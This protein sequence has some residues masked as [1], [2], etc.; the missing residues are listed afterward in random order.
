MRRADHGTGSSWSEYLYT[1]D[2]A[3]KTCT[4][5]RIPRSESFDCSKLGAQCFGNCARFYG[6]HVTGSGGG[7]SGGAGNTSSNGQNRK[8][9]NGSSGPQKSN[10]TS[11]YQTDVWSPI[12]NY[13]TVTWH[14]VSSSRA[15]FNSFSALSFLLGGQIGPGANDNWPL[16]GEPE[17]MCVIANTMC[18]IP[19]NPSETRTRSQIFACREAFTNCMVRTIEATAYRASRTGW[20]RFTPLTITHI[21]TIFPDGARVEISLEAVTAT[22]WPPALPYAGAPGV[23]YPAPGMPAFP[24]PE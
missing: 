19:A 18:V 15:S 14:S 5:S 2:G 21:G 12:G 13:G 20:Q 22:Y 16:A 1:E 10:G 3:L 6:L 9:E 11:G 7:G 8:S 17:E 24:E 23:R 4:G